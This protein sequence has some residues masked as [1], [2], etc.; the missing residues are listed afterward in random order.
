VR[1]AAIHLMT[2][3]DTY[4][5][6]A[7]GMPSPVESLEK[8]AFAAENAQRIADVPESDPDKLARLMVEGIERFLDTTAGRPGDQQVTWHCGFPID[9][10]TLTSVLLSE[11]ILH[12]FDM[13][14]ATGMPWPIDPDHARLIDVAMAPVFATVL[15]P[16]TTRGL[17]VGY[18]LE[19]RGVGR[20]TVRFV[21]GEYRLEPPDS[22]PVAC[23]ISADPVGFLL[24]GSGRLEQSD[25][26]ALGLLSAGGDHPELA[27]GFKDLFVYP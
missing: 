13:A 6:I 7:N 3:P 16:A 14:K 8:A 1:E 24:V 19:L 23:T 5:D 12:G 11:Q 21:D 15:N 20:L 17:T 4:G 26:I 18:D 27:L 2:W 9:L 22:G 25:A 10:A